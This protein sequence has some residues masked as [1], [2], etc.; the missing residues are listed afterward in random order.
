MS[1]GRGKRGT[2]EQNIE[3]GEKGTEKGWGRRENGL[4]DEVVETKAHDLYFMSRPSMSET[5]FLPILVLLI[6]ID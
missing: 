2:E 6:R 5:Y 1:L 4:K 3:L